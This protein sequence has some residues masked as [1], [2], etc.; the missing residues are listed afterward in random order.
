MEAEAA[1]LIG[2]GLACSGMIGAGV[3]LGHIFGNYL[4]AAIRNPSAA[5]G[6][7]GNLIFGFAVTEALGIFSLLIAIMLLFVV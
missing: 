2:A 5:Q 6:Q 7:F 3:G 4:S 1:K